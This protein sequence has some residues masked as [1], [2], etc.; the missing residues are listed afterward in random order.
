MGDLLIRGVSVRVKQKLRRMAMKRHMSVN[1]I[2]LEQLD[3]WEEYEDQDKTA[4]EKQAEAIKR[5]NE[6]RQE[7]YKKYGLSNIAVKYIRE[8]RDSR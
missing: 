7:T 4:D 8:G 2:L 3:K 5:L 6:I 1:R